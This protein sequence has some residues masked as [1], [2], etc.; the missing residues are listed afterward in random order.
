MCTNRIDFAGLQ[1]RCRLEV[2]RVR[3]KQYRNALRHAKYVKLINP[4]CATVLALAG[5][6]IAITLP[7]V[8]NRWFKADYCFNI[9]EQ[10]SSATQLLHIFHHLQHLPP[11][12]A[13]VCVRLTLEIS[14]ALRCYSFPVWT[15]RQIRPCPNAS[16]IRVITLITASFGGWRHVW[17]EPECFFTSACA[18]YT[19]EYAWFTGLYALVFWDLKAIF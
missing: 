5:C 9:T 8:L 4:E 11:D 3:S 19:V 13:H 12:P 15:P 18:W 10:H 17:C 14:T 6:K 7:R 2:P 16:Q 1:W